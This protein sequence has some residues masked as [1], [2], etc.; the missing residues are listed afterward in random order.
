MATI[1]AEAALTAESNLLATTNFVYYQ[2]GIIDVTD[3]AIKPLADGRWAALAGTTWGEF[4]TYQQIVK[5][6][7]WTSDVVDLG[8][9]DVFTL[10]IETD[11]EGTL[12]TFFIDVSDT[13]DFAGEERHFI[14]EEGD[15]DVPA[16]TGRYIY[17]TAIL[18]GAA[19]R[20]M[21]I[22][23]S[24]DSNQIQ[25]ANVNTS[26]LPGTP[27]SRQLPIPAVSLIKDI[28][29]QP[30]VST[31]YNVDLYV[32]ST[33]TS[34]VLIPMVVSKSGSDPRIGLFGIDNQPRDGL[35]DVTVSVMPRQAM[36]A[37]NLIVI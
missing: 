25:L 37:G 32:S 3:G 7:R 13:G 14:I 34:T 5:Q 35:V 12:E 16:F 21:T 24:T 33:P 10:N 20:R 8:R 19:L 31:T 23:A 11:F 36:F 15:F 6:I 28:V 2:D 18:D 17:V 27:G 22:T 4:T 26:E 9:V 30:K 1:T 29:I